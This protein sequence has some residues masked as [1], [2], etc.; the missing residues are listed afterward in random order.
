MTAEARNQ[1]VDLIKIIA[2]SMVV[3]LHTI[4][5]FIDY[6]GIDL[7]FIVYEL[8]IAA[9]PLFF[10]VS[11]YLLIGRP[12]AGY[13][14][15]FKK[16][17]GIVRFVFIIALAYWILRFTYSILHHRSGFDF[18]FFLK[19]FFGA[20]LHQGSLSFFWYLGAMCIIYLLYPIINALRND[21]K[22]YLLLLFVLCLIQN[23]AFIANITDKAELAVNQ[24]FRLWNWLTFFMI[25]GLMKSFDADIRVL[26]A[27]T[28][29]FAALSS[30][31]LIWLGPHVRMPFEHYYG[32]PV[33]IVFASCLFK[34]ISSIKIKRNRIIAELS[35]TFLPVYALHIPVINLCDKLIPGFRD[36]EWNGTAYWLSMLCIT[37]FL[38][39][40]IMRIPYVKNIFKI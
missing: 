40:A 38:S 3:C 29:L 15:S 27:M 36:F 32:C 4:Y 28:V 1:S 2:M 37:I 25:G 33:L 34:F 22:K 16:I 12:D 26:G 30:L 18:I 35:S 39:L 6:D 17:Y 11:G 24:T 10:M 8:S 13:R 20:F 21:V 14:Y 23:I 31:T 5:P 19:N 7:S 9:I